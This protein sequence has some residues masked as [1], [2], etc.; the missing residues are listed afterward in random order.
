MGKV[1]TQLLKTKYNGCF[2]VMQKENS[3]V[4]T[5]DFNLMKKYIKKGYDITIVNGVNDFVRPNI[6]K[7]KQK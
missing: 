6:I 7:R 2:V 5:N 3:A 4:G 1:S